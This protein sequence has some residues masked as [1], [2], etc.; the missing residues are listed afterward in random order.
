MAKWA[1]W[2][3]VAMFGIATGI[4]ANLLTPVGKNAPIGS[5]TPTVVLVI[6]F[7]SHQAQSF[8]YSANHARPTTMCP[9]GIQ[10]ICL[11]WAELLPRTFDL[12]HDQAALIPHQQVWRPLLPKTCLMGH[13]NDGA[14]GLER[15]LDPAPER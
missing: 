3:V 9:R 7:G 2:L 13:K 8:I 12:H 14:L 10:T 6:I 4:G 11:Q 1:N 5:L 15:A